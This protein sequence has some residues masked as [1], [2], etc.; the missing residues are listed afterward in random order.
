MLRAAVTAAK[1]ISRETNSCKQVPSQ[2][3]T[4]EAT[5]QHTN[6][7]SETSECVCVTEPS[8]GE[9]RLPDCLYD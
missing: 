2:A 4:H 1:C 3:T 7:P 6:K 5:T 9:G 8:Y